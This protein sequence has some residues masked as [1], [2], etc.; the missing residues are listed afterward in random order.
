M[1]LPTS[2]H[3]FGAVQV[4]TA[5][6]PFTPRQIMYRT[7][8]HIHDRC[9]KPDAI[10]FKHYGGR[11]I[12]VCEQWHSFEGFYADV[13]PRPP[14]KTLDR[15]P[16][17]DGN[18]EPSNVRWATVDEQIRNRNMTRW[19]TRGGETMCLKD[20]TR[21]LGLRYNTIQDRVKKGWPV[22]LALTLPVSASNSGLRLANSVIERPRR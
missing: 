14:G 17:G 16:N 19:I 10:G 1:L 22:E 6:H 20:W 7:W 8:A 21:R 2:D 15:W 11:G 9:Y 12:A 18:Y 5:K 4:T 3:S 13:S